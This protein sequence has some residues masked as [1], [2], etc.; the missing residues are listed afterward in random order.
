MLLSRIKTFCSGRESSTQMGRW[1]MVNFSFI[2]I[3]NR[4]FLWET[5]P[6]KGM[7][8]FF[9]SVQGETVNFSTF[10]S[11]LLADDV[12]MRIIIRVLECEK[13]CITGESSLRFCLFLLLTYVVQDAQMV[14]LST[15]ISLHIKSSSY[16]RAVSLSVSYPAVLMTRLGS[17]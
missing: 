2:D 8:L 11:S 16:W 13:L 17:H 15:L 5:A 9:G 10:L 3:V 12:F 7:N 14:T 6:R 4:D 1:S